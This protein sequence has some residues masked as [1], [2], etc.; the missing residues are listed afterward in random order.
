LGRIR[1][2]RIIWSEF[3]VYFG[4]NSPSTSERIPLQRAPLQRSSSGPFWLPLFWLPRPSPASSNF[5]QTRALRTARTVSSKDDP[6][7]DS[8]LGRFQ[9]L[10]AGLAGLGAGLGGEAAGKDTESQ[11]LSANSTG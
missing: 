6:K 11:G 2:E 5:P 3:P 10:G 1:L 4:A 8:G 7:T 9:R